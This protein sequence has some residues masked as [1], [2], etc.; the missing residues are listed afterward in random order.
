MLCLLGSMFRQPAPLG[1]RERR[2]AKGIFTRKTAS[3]KVRLEIAQ[4]VGAAVFRRTLR[5]TARKRDDE[6]EAILEVSEL[7]LSH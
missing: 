2:S 1:F 4:R 3:L 7:R 5:E 6:A